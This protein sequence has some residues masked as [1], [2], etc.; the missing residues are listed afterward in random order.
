MEQ[1]FSDYLDETAAL[2]RGSPDSEDIFEKKFETLLTP[3]QRAQEV[4]VMGVSSLPALGVTCFH[5]SFCLLEHA[6]DHE[7]C[8]RCLVLIGEL[9]VV[10][11]DNSLALSDLLEDVPWSQDSSWKTGAICSYSL[12]CI[13][14]FPGGVQP[15]KKSVGIRLQLDP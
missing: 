9:G 4:W 3:R 11:S 6:V 2:Y 7:Y 5:L 15:G 1:R 13:R 14:L 10:W 12:V 8:Q